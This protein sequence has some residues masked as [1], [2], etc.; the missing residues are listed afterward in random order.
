MWTSIMR[1]AYCAAELLVER[2]RRNIGIIAGPDDMVAPKQRTM[3]CVNGL[4]DQD[5][6]VGSD[7]GRIYCG[8]RF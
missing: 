6:A 3:G 8:A 4:A 2:G 1:A 7:L 5:E